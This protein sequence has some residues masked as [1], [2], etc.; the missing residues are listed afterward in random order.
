LEEPLWE[1]AD[2]KIEIVSPVEE[3]PVMESPVEPEVPSE[4]PIEE[5][6]ES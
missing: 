4:E 3:E 1:V 6:T 5:E 2:K